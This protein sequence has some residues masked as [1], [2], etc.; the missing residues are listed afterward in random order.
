MLGPRLRVRCFIVLFAA[1]SS[2][3]QAQTFSVLYNFGASPN[4]PTQPFYSGIIAQGRD[5]DLYSSAFGFNTLTGTEGVAFKITP[6]GILTSLAS[7]GGPDGILPYSGLTL[8]SDGNFY[9]TTYSGGV[10]AQAPYGTVFRMTPAG[11]LNVLYTFTNGTDG[12][13]PIAPPVEGADGNYY[14]TT[15]PGCNGQGGYGSVYKITP[16][17]TFTVL[18]AFDDTHGSTPDDPLLLARDGNLYGTTQFG[19]I[20][21]AG[22]VF[23]LTPR[24]A[25]T[26]LINFDNA[27]GGLPTSPLIQAADGNFYGTTTNGG[28]FGYGVVFRVTP[29][30]RFRVLHHMNGTTD[31]GVPYA[32]LVQATDNNVYGVNSYGGAI[33]PGCPTGCGTIFRVTPQGVFSVVYNFDQTTGQTPYSTMFQHTNGMLYGMTNLGGTAAGALCGVGQCGVFYSLNIGAAPFVRPLPGSSRVGNKIEIIGQGFTGLTGVSFN[34][35]PASFT[36]QGDTYITAIVPSGATSGFLTVTTP[37]GTLKSNTPFRVVPQIKTFTPT[38]GAPGTAVAIT[39]VSLSQT[40]SVTFGGIAATS[41][42]V[43]SDTQVTVTVPTGA[44]T[45]S[46]VITTPGGAAT[47]TQS[48]TVT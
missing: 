10:P 11:S 1:L 42:T 43:N 7:F 5:G 12:A 19:G 46:I 29:G 37:N 32:G 20:H 23:K 34:G 15:C 48:F 33:G 16:S 17:G 47:S 3:A 26:V 28:D 25:I 38:R 4:D 27:H 14:G 9:G 40:K 8:G 44:K 41:F 24:G 35:T 2:L 6:T 21:G 18:Y 30:G 22:E 36:V 31:G 39:G 13:L 45:G